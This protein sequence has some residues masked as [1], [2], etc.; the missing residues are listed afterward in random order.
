MLFKN[1]S[2]YAFLRVNIGT[3]GLSLS[4]F[5]IKCPVAFAQVLYKVLNIIFTPFFSVKSLIIYVNF[6]SNFNYLNY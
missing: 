1:N 3:S 5:P 4:V 2:I 6:F